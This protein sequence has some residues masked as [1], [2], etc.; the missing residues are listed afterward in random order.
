MKKQIKIDLAENNSFVLYTR[1][2]S[3]RT[4]EDGTVVSLNSKAWIDHIGLGHLSFYCVVTKKSG[5]S[6]RKNFRNLETAIS[7]FD[8]IENNPWHPVCICYVVSVNKQLRQDL[9]EGKYITLGKKQLAC[10][11]R[12]DITVRAT[13]RQFTDDLGYFVGNV[14]ITKEQEG[15]KPISKNF[16]N[17]N[18]A[19]DYYDG[20]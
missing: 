19:I 7:Y 15:E 2:I 1:E 17:L 10:K 8:S 16:L 20:I 13:L 5:V 12:G 11:K 14:I 18:D 4:T 6:R 3:Y 9:K